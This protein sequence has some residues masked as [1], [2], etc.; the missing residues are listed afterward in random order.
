MPSARLPRSAEGA[1]FPRETLDR[2]LD[3]G[4]Q[5]IEEILRAQRSALGTEST[6]G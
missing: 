4:Q 3:L 5:G 1:T 2:M 6:A